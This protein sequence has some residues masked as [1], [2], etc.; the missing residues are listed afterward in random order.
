MDADGDVVRTL[1]TDEALA[2]GSYSRS[3]DGRDDAG[4][5]VPRGTYRSVVHASDGDL[6]AT[7]AVVGARRRVPG[8][9]QRRDARRASSGSR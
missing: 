5:I 8:V 9:G 4:H 2:A 3:W 6:A 7:Q 1:N